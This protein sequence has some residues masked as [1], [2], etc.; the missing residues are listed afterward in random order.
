MQF[1]SNGPQSYYAAWLKDPL[2][3]P[4][5]AARMHDEKLRQLTDADGPAELDQIVP[6]PAPRRLGAPT[7]PDIDGGD[8]GALPPPPPA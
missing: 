5:L 8:L 2:T 1:K 6:A 7:G 4:G 3:E